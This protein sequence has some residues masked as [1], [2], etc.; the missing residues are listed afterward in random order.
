M[1]KGERIR[2]LRESNNMSQTELAS[3]I[4]V[5]KQTLYKYEN[6]IVTNIPSDKIEAIANVF[7]V[8]PSYIMSWEEENPAAPSEDRASRLYEMYQ[9]ATP[10][11]RQAI[12]LLL[13]SHQS[14]PEHPLEES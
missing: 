14:D 2:Q 11:V 3:R 7:H 10:E 9:K 8:S 13:K 5:S 4:D 12:D 6:N 1:N